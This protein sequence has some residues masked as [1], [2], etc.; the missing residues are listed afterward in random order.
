M[1]LLHAPDQRG[2]LGGPQLDVAP[3]VLPC[4]TI[5][6]PADSP[7]PDALREAGGIDERASSFYSLYV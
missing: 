5:E 7:A 6:W 3:L 4:S 2:L 1:L